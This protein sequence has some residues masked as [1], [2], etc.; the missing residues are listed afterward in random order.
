M[1]AKISSSAYAT[2]AG[3]QSLYLIPP[4]CAM[5]AFCSWKRSPSRWEPFMCLSTHRITQLSSREVRD[6]LSKP[7][8][9]WSKHCWT[10]LEYI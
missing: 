4:C 5:A 1:V 9:Q 6:L 8:T 7:L 10:R 2:S 3:L